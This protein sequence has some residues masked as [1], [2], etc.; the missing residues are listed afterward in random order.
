MTDKKTSGAF[1]QLRQLDLALYKFNDVWKRFYFMNEG[2]LLESK[3]SDQI[4][5][6]NKANG[7]CAPGSILISNTKGNLRD[8]IKSQ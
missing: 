8:F 6:I 5:Q 2:V 4:S 3:E 7:K 1:L